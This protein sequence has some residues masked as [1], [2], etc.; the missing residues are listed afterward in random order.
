M[1]FY[2]W[3]STVG[4]QYYIQNTFKQLFTDAK[5]GQSSQTVYCSLQLFTTDFACHVQNEGMIVTVLQN[6]V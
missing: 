3:I 4:V 1:N 2:F 6:T 5:P